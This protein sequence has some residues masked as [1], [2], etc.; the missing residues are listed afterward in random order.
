MMTRWKYI[1]PIA[2]PLKNSHTCCIC[3]ISICYIWQNK[4][5]WR[6]I[7]KEVCRL[8]STSHATHCSNIESVDGISKD[9]EK[10][11]IT[12]NTRKTERERESL[13]LMQWE[14][15]TT[16]SLLWK[17]VYIYTRKVAT[18]TRHGSQTR[19]LSITWDQFIEHQTILYVCVCVCW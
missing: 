6:R 14:T 18:S 5:R 7:Y 19:D 16:R 17:C 8:M 15:T 1:V 9:T 4:T 3:I 2:K 11:N 13:A 10:Y 12:E